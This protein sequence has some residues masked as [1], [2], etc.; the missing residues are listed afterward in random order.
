M[1][2]IT[3]VFDKGTMGPHEIHQAW[4]VIR[5]GNAWE[6]AL[7][8]VSTRVHPSHEAA[9]VEMAQRLASFGF[10]LVTN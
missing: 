5:V 4:T 6:G 2:Q 7:L 1:Q 3:A 8:R 10:Q 9:R